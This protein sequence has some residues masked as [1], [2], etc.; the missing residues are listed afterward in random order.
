[1]IAAQLSAQTSHTIQ[2]GDSKLFYR[3]FGNGQPVVIINGGP[4][5]NSDGFAAMAEKIS[6]VNCQ[7][8]IYD[9]RGTGKSTI[10]TVNSSTITMDLMVTDLENL[11]QHLKIKQWIV[12]GHSFGGM[13]ASYYA[14]V[15]PESIKSII[16]S[17]SGGIDMG[18]MA[19]VGGINDRLNTEERKSLNYWN[20]QIAA[21]DTTYN[22]RLQRGKALANAY[23]YNKANAAIIAERLTQGNTT[24]NGLIWQDLIKIKFN[25]APKLSGFSKPV[26][27]IQ[28]KN[29]II[30]FKTAEIAHKAL[31]NSKIVIMDHCG[32]YGWLDNPDIYFPALHDFLNS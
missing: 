5:M 8:I 20:E 29:D 14:T 13:L 26:L 27:I 2:S 7:T 28:G 12:L 31:R 23:V 1:M 18:L 9:Q 6:M 3:S 15:H 16:L 25:C 30:E 22:A 19:Y 10:S 17:S 11:R 24:V 21:G 32:H 4:G